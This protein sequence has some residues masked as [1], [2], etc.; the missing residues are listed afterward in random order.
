MSWLFTRCESFRPRCV[1]RLKAAWSDRYA[2]F[3]GAR[4][5]R[6]EVK[7]RLLSRDPFARPSLDQLEGHDFFSNE[8]N[9]IH[10]FLENLVLKSQEERKTFF[11]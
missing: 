11:M 1:S 4:Q 8:F 9:Q 2:E 7:R 3:P 5:F 6:D 10:S